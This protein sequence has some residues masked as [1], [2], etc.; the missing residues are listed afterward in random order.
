MSEMV[1]KTNNVLRHLLSW[2]ELTEKEQSRFDWLDKEE[3]QS[4][5]FFR[6]KGYAYHMSEFMCVDN[7]PSFKGWD[8][9]HA[10][11]YFSGVLVKL[12]DSDSILCGRYCC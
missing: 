10:D 12:I 5:N 6:Y 9:Y 8:G 1:I 3:L 11:S 2:E 4:I 7:A